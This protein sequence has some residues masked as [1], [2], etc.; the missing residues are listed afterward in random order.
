MKQASSRATA[1]QIASNAISSSRSSQFSGLSITDPRLAVFLSMSNVERTRAL[2]A[3][4]DG[5]TGPKVRQEVTSWIVQRL[6]VERLVPQTYAEWR[7]VVREAMLYF[8]SHLSTPRLV[9]KVIEQLELAPDTLPEVRLFR[10]IA[11]VPAL[12]KLGQVIARNRHLHPAVRRALTQLENGICD[13][14]IDDIRKIIVQELEPKLERNAVEIEGK[15]FSEASVSAVVRFTWYNPK[16]RTREQGVFKVLKPYI[17]EYFAEEMDLL[18]RLAEHLGSKHAEYGFAEHVLSD[19]FQDVR[20]LLQHEVRFRREQIHLHEASRLYSSFDTIRIPRVIRPLCTSTITALTLETGEKIT[21]A[22]ARVPK[23]RRARIAGQLTE[24]VIAV[25][26]LAS[27]RR[28]MFHAD[29]HAG[30]L[31]YS[32]QAGTLTLLDWAL[33]AHIDEE[34][35]RQIALLFIMTVLRDQ[36]GVCAAIEAL[37]PGGGKRSSRRTRIIR[38]QVTQY[39]EDQPLLR[40]PQAVDAMELLE[41][42]AWQGVRLPSNLIMLRKVVFTLDGI[43]HELAGENAK[44]ELVIA[45][46]LLRQ[47]VKSPTNV[48]WPLSVRDWVAVSWSAIFYGSRVA[49]G[50]AQQFSAYGQIS[51]PNEIEAAY[52]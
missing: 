30:N 15:I 45:R 9:P 14:A 32:N 48:G 7:P 16:T 47:W 20:R 51:E 5:A 35:R 40:L 28:T 38:Q 4:L 27:G 36:D 42:I 29:P 49:R 43:L 12:Q 25:P 37:S 10:L 22:A 11:K 41:R 52:S 2:T 46:H 6:S 33:T 3:M 39:F 24:A 18:A 21:K 13:V 44:M 50:I 23:W 19:T 8:G 1:A 31:L 17:R 26:L 34:Q